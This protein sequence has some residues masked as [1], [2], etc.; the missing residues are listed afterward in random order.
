VVVRSGGTTFRRT[1]DVEAGGT[2]SLVISS[3][4]AA[5]AWGWVEL[6]TPFPVQA[7]EGGVV[8]GTS[9]IERI[10]LP[11]GDHTI[12][13][14]AAPFGFRQTSRV[15][16]SAGRGGRLSPTI[17]TAPI[18]INALP[19][20]EVIIDGTRV[21]DTPL[22][23]VMQPIGDHEVVFRHPQLGERRQTIRVTLRE[24]LRVSVDMRSR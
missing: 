21:G 19:W 5:A 22:A 16:V 2:A 12:D 3:G 23:N 10:M 14:V 4:A 8:I 15:R 18:N 24:P 17:P 7:V 1:V 6:D 11:P 9:D 20:A 13:L